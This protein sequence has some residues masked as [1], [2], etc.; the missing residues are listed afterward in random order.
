MAITI[1]VGD[2]KNVH[3]ADKFDVGQRLALVARKVAYGE[4]I[5]ASGPLYQDFKIE[6]EGK[7]RISFKETGSGLVIGQSPWYAPTVTPFPKD[8][9]IGFFIAGSDKKWVEADAQ[10]DGS[11]VIVSSQQVSNPVAVRYGWANSPR[12]NL[13]NK[14]GL[15]A[16]PFRTDIE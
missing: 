14:E 1:D 6:K 5:V 11:S 4:K 3:P 8:K 13:Y 12:C 15:P 2:P 7:I 16:S 10:I 9:L